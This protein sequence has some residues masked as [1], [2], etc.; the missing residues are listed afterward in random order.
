MPV[1]EQLLLEGEISISHRAEIDVFEFIGGYRRNFARL[2]L[3]RAG[4]VIEVSPLNYSAKIFPNKSR[5]AFAPLDLIGS[6]GHE[7]LCGHKLAEVA[8]E[9]REGARS[10]SE[11]VEN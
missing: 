8:N 4:Q 5:I 6:D 2:K 1:L 7:A 9:A 10:P 11:M 3:Y